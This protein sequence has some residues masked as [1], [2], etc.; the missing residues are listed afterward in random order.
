[1]D[2][3]LKSAT[4]WALFGLLGA[5]VLESLQETVVKRQLDLPI[6]DN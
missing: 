1:V 2:S 5:W 3:L 4:G 6:G